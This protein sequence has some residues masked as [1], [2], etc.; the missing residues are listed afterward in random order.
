MRQLCV[1]RAIL[2]STILKKK[3]FLKSMILIKELFLKSMILEKKAFLKSM[4]LKKIF[5]VLSGFESNF[6]SSRQISNPL[7]YNASD[8]ELKNL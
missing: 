5:F 8:F 2:K 6:F 7:L 4:I 1:L 3:F